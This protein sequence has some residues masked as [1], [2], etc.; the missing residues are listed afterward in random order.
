MASFKFNVKLKQNKVNKITKNAKT[1]LVKTAE[2]LHTD[3]V[4]SGVMPFDSFHLLLFLDKE[5][6]CR[7]KLLQIQA[8]ILVRILKLARNILLRFFKNALRVLLPVLQ[9]I[10]RPLEP[11][12]F[13]DSFHKISPWV[14]L[15]K[16]LCFNAHARKYHL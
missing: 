2:A 10:C 4:E 11:F 8:E 16:H 9:N 3:V 1:A 15:L 5:T 6:E 7:C 12:V 14:F 13:Q